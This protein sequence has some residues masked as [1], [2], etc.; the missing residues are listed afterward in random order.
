MNVN[1]FLKNYRIQLTFLLVGAVGGFLYW[2][3]VGCKSGT[4][5]IRSVWYWTVL[6]GSTVGY[7]V[8]D[9]IS[10]IINKRKKKEENEN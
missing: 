3:F 5:P 10:D 1:S 2:K 7:L 6:W 8:G 4:C 9:F